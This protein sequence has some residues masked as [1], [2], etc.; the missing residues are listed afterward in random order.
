[1]DLEGEQ[2]AQKRS[3]SVINVV[4]GLVEV[5]NKNVHRRLNNLIGES[6]IAD[7]NNCIDYRKA[8]TRWK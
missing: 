5:A 6:K 8:L 7:V 2:N 1:M 3:S 4:H